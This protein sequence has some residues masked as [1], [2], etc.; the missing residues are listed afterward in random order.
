MDFE[1]FHVRIL[2][3]LAGYEF[4]EDN[5]HEYLGQQYFNTKSLTPTQYKKSKEMT[6][7]I[8]YNDW[9]DK[10]QHIELFAKIKHYKDQKWKEYQQNG[11]LVSDISGKPITGIKKKT[12]LLPFILHNYETESNV[13]KL[14][15]ILQ[16]LSEQKSSLI[17]YNFDSITLDFCKEDEYLLPGIKNILE[18]NGKYPVKQKMGNSLNFE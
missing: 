13:I 6:F 3:H 17:L 4:T 9:I 11:M 5:I 16:L 2:G 10:Y 15:K 7:K 12:Q 18:E 14:Y 8:I 1:S